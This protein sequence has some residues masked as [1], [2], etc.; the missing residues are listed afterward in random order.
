MLNYSFCLVLLLSVVLTNAS[1]TKPNKIYSV[2]SNTFIAVQS[3]Y[4]DP[5]TRIVHT[6]V[7]DNSY[8]RYHYLAVSPEGKLLYRHVFQD[9]YLA[10]MAIIRGKG[11]GKHLYLA[12]M[13]RPQAGRMNNTVN[14]T[15]SA[16]GGR[17]WTPAV[18]ILAPGEHKVLQDMLYVPQIGRLYFF[19]VTYSGL[20]KMVSKTLDSSK[21][22][23]EVT[24][25]K[26]AEAGYNCARAAYN[27]KGGKPIL[28]VFY[29]EDPI[30]LRYSR[31]DTYGASWSASR[32]IADDNIWDI[33]VGMDLDISSN[34]YV[35]FSSSANPVR[36][37]YTKDFGTSF[38]PIIDITDASVLY[39]T[40]HG[41]ALC[42]TKEKPRLVS[43]FVYEH[44]AGDGTAEYDVWD[45]KTMQRDQRDHPFKPLE[46]LNSGGLVCATVKSKLEI[47]VFATQQPP[48]QDVTYVHV[49][50][51]TSDML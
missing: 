11:D 17:T 49:A 8:D 45:L 2:A 3:A 41:F 43:F 46:R 15:E 42:G 30:G 16:D 5:S 21:I 20:V 4:R 1:W 29:N 50:K 38:E 7:N 33:F 40:A 6:V 23:A 47:T 19:F 14:Y 27:M 51:E 13:A 34:I 36:M 18:S 25:A 48:R 28:H 12:I 37:T 39:D 26:G 24:I 32:R 35:A 10:Q 44:A 31:S 22:S 9:Q